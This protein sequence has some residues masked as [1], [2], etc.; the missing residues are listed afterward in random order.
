VSAPSLVTQTI[1]GAPGPLV[2]TAGCRA[3][4]ARGSCRARSPRSVSPR[5]PTVP[6]CS[7]IARLAGWPGG[8]DIWIA[9]RAP[10]IPCIHDAISGPG[11]A[12]AARDPAQR[13]WCD[14][15]G[16]DLRPRPRGSLWDRTKG[17]GAG[18]R[19]YGLPGPR[20]RRPADVADRLAAGTAAAR[21]SPGLIDAAW[22]ALRYPVE[23]A[24]TMGKALYGILSG[25]DRA[26][27]V[28]LI[29]IA[30]FDRAPASD[31]VSDPAVL[32]R[33]PDVPGLRDRDRAAHP[34]Q[35]RAHRLRGGDHGTRPGN[36]DRTLPRHPPHAELA[37]AT[38]GCRPA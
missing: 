36:A 2:I 34:S 6:C 16:C 30:E 9:R 29:R 11:R 28:V 8:W 35:D 22:R 1:D 37:P 33:P 27:R 38:S 21:Y 7:G 3:G 4:R 20:L 18:R 24:H 15:R 23:Q 10:A 32:R 17:A 31:V 19:R 12:R 13:T 5:A 14:E 26:D 25:S